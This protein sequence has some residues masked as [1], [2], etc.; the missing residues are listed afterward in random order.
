MVTTALRLALIAASLSALD[1]IA[2]PARQP[3]A[4]VSVDTV[5]IP[6]PS[7]FHPTA[8]A[9]ADFTGDGHVDAV[10]CGQTGAFLL[11][12]SD[13]HGALRPIPQ[14]GSEGL[15]GEHPFGVVSA[16]VNGDGRID[17]VVAN[18]DAGYVTVLINEENG[19][20]SS[21]RLP[22][23][24]TPHPHTVAAAD[25]NGDGLVDVI[26]DSWG[27]RRLIWL[28]ANRD[29]GWDSPGV[30]VDVA[31]A[32]YVNIV[33]TDLNGDGHVD[34]AFP[35]AAPTAP[36]NSVS[37]LLG[38]G[39]GGFRPSPESPIAA[40]RAPFMISAGDVNGDGRPDLL[41]VNYSGHIT[42]TSKDGLTWIRND[43][44]GHFTAFPDRVVLGHGSWH[45][46]SGDL[47]GDGLADAAFINAADDTVA[48][49]YGSRAGPQ[50]GGT[51]KV[52]PEPHRVALADLHG[53]G[54]A[55]LLVTTEQLDELLVA[56]IR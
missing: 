22:V 11:L 47:N 5:L 33:A 16:D 18:H 56:S 8:I 21:R 32:P 46:A 9:V 45:I 36:F 50:P 26:T 10:L 27:D 4:A 39:H 54:H 52:M 15:C 49:A 12:A 38:D 35:N 25:L 28:P 43:G 6:L 51:V 37:M 29:G 1:S 7:G 24:S 55:A 34:L 20:F 14:T 53:N 40:G 30:P 42:D 19:R 31:R 17:V 44:G 23:R 41:V 48:L 2:P 3:V 13:S